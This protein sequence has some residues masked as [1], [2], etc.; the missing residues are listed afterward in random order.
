M[1]D[2]VRIFT[3]SKFNYIQFTESKPNFF[4]VKNQLFINSNI[5]LFGSFY[6]F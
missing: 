6:K 2:L 5:F 3:Q 1:R 4:F